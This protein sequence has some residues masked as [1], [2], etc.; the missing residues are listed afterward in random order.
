MLE[1]RADRAANGVAEPLSL[2]TVFQQCLVFTAGALREWQHRVLLVRGPGQQW[3]WLSPEGDVAAVDLS[4]LRIKPLRRSSQF[5][6][7][8]AGNIVVFEPMAEDELNMYYLDARELASIM[9]FDIPTVSPTAAK[10][11]V[12]DPISSSFGQEIPPSVYMDDGTLLGRGSVGV[13]DIDGTWTRC[14]KLTG[15]DPWPAYLRLIAEGPR[16]DSRLMGDLRD[17]EGKRFMTF[18]QSL[19]KV[20]PVDMIGWETGV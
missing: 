9:G 20:S 13:V 18:S 1:A 17:S 19:L 2:D 5:P 4:T 8:L 16:D 11:F 14:V 3:I 15:V 6:P 12:S 7:A 10:W